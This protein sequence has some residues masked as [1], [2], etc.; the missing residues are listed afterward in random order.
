[1]QEFIYKGY[2]DGFSKN[3]RAVYMFKKENDK[4]LYYMFGLTRNL[5][6]GNRVCISYKH[7]SPYRDGFLLV[8]GNITDEQC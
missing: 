7:E 4:T 6:I 8:G 1:M 2:N 3:R 5:E